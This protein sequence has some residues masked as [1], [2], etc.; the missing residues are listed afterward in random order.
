MR[1][2]PGLVRVGLVA[3]RGSGRARCAFRRT[4]LRLAALIDAIL[5]EIE[6]G[7][8]PTRSREISGD[9]G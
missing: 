1:R 7:S 5:A 8:G 9:D 2:W 4:G 6:A 3:A